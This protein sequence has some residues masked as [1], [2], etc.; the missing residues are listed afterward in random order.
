MR[1]RPIH[2]A[3]ETC[4]GPRSRLRS[5][6]PSGTNRPVQA[7]QPHHD[8]AQRYCRGVTGIRGRSGSQDEEGRG[9]AFALGEIFSP[10]QIRLAPFS[11]QVELVGMGH[12]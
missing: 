11:W 7:Y 5:R 10:G 8:M 2:E 12:G 9:A 6:T 1:S 4:S 3:V